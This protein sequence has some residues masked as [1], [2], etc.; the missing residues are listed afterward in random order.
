MILRDFLKCGWMIHDELM[1]LTRASQLNSVETTLSLA[2]GR[3]TNCQSRSEVL[4]DQ[5]CTKAG[6]VVPKKR[7][8]AAL[9]STSVKM[10]ARQTFPINFLDVA[11]GIRRQP[12]PEK[13]RYSEQL[14]H[15]GSGLR[16][17]PAT[18]G[19]EDAA[20]KKEL[21]CFQLLTSPPPAGMGFS[22]HL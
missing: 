4:D 5:R 14:D 2:L 18:T 7:D 1:S 6:M 22:P 17:L 12:F 3:C 20:R 9:P 21:L 10:M 8:A 15:V 19:L 11:E 16:A 13:V